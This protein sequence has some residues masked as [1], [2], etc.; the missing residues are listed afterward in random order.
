MKLWF[1][2]AILIS[3]AL[4]AGKRFHGKMHFS[5]APFLFASRFASRKWG[6][7]EGEAFRVNPV[8]PS[9]LKRRTFQSSQNVPVEI[10]AAYFTLVGLVFRTR[11]FR[12][13]F[14]HCNY[15]VISFFFLYVVPLNT[16]FR[17]RTA[18]LHRF[19]GYKVSRSLLPF[20]VVA[21]TNKMASKRSRDVGAR[22]PKISKFFR[23]VLGM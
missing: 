1:V 23:T 13:V 11:L 5:S 20:T 7:M 12:V 4:P 10:S 2:A 8:R 14:H 16:T 9:S 19:S 3:A 17:L 22:T 18:S 21:S 6:E 15:K